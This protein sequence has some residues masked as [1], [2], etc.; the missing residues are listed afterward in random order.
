V[1]TAPKSQHN[2]C[3]GNNVACGSGIASNGVQI[4]KNVENNNQSKQANNNSF[5]A[6]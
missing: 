3:N 2:Q 4:L 6:Q 1:A 5:I